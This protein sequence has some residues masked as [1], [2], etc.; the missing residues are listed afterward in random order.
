MIDSPIY[1]VACLR[2]IVR[3]CL[4]FL[5]KH[6]EKRFTRLGQALLES[7]GTVARDACPGLASIFIA[8]TAAIMGILYAGEIE[9]LLPVGPLFL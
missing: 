1:F 3:I 9:I 5:A 2:A 8:A 4:H 7:F 6:I